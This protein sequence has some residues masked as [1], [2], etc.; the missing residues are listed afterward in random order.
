MVLAVRIQW[1]RNFMVKQLNEK[2][3]KT[4]IL[5]ILAAACVS[6]MS[7]RKTLFPDEKLTMER[8]PYTGSELRIDG[9]YYLQDEEYEY[10]T[11]RFLFANGVILSAG[12][13]S[14]LDLGVVESRLV[15]GYN[16][17]ED[18]IGW[19]VFAIAG[20]QII[21]EQWN[22]TTGGGLPIVRSKGH[23]ENDTTFRITELYF[24]NMNETR[25]Y[26]RALHFKQFDNKPDSVNSFIP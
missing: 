11:V 13:Y 9:Y 14:S 7:C 18:K 17:I 25:Y 19:G 8:V 16:T 12:S 2:I 26:D 10:T 21:I 5:V 20:D 3:M 15:Q 1:R 22:G 6:C 24:S 4:T 23:I